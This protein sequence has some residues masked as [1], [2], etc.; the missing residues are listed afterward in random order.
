MM[1]EQRS[2]LPLENVLLYQQM[3]LKVY[4]QRWGCTMAE[5]A[6]EPLGERACRPNDPGLKL[7]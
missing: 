5:R 6:A 1:S 2:C 4:T 3:H 7:G